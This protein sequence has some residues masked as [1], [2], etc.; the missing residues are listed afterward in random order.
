MSLQQ[1]A[2][3]L[4]SENIDLVIR[5]NKDGIVYGITYVD[6]KNAV[7]FNG[8]DLGKAYSAK[9]I[10]ERGKVVTK[11]MAEVSNDFITEV[12]VKQ[13]SKVNPTL[14]LPKTNKSTLL[15]LLANPDSKSSY[16]PDSLEKGKQ[17]RKK[18]R[19]Q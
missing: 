9:G 11:L 7:V 2:D 16:V 1:F 12:T 10:V 13:K 4:K 5:E 6:H 8:S 3:K 15:E 19:K 18:K 14:T 17:K